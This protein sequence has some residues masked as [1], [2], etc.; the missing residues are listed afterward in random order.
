M[1]DL[2]S[3]YRTVHNFGLREAGRNKSL[4]ESP[5][6]TYHLEYYVAYVTKSLHAS[7]PFKGELHH[8][9]NVLKDGFPLQHNLR[10][11]MDEHESGIWKANA[12]VVIVLA[13]LR[14]VSNGEVMCKVTLD[15]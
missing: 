11:W 4:A 15:G 8:S 5:F 2:I 14:R 7:Q 6:S 13:E 12:E 10:Q 9:W 1:S 3:D